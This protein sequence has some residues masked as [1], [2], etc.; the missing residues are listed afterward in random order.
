MNI[1]DKLKN[2]GTT[3]ALA[4]GQM[5]LSDCDVIVNWDNQN[6]FWWNETCALVLEVFGLPGNRYES[7]PDSDYMLFTFKSKK[8]ADLCRILLSERL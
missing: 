8:D 5:T 6:G 3:H 2:Y 4:L 7:K 1:K